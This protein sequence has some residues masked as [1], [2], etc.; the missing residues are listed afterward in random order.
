MMLAGS[1]QE[2]DLLDRAPSLASPAWKPERIGE[3]E[4]QGVLGEGGMGIVFEPK[5]AAPKRT[6][7]LK[8]VRAGLV[9]GSMLRRFWHEA[10]VLGWLNHPGIAQVY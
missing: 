5:Q 4:T 6:I 9:T 7:A 2:S 10:E 3:Y 1:A 8:V